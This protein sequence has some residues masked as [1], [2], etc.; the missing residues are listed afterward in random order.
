MVQQQ[1]QQP[2][3]TTE[4]K[5]RVLTAAARQGKL[6]ILEWMLTNWPSLLYTLSRETVAR[7]HGNVQLLFLMH[8]FKMQL[9]SLGASLTDSAHDSI[10]W[11]RHDQHHRVECLVRYLNVNVCNIVMS[12]TRSTVEAM[13]HTM[14]RNP[15]WL[16]PIP[17][18]FHVDQPRHS[19]GPCDWYPWLRGCRALKCLC[20]VLRCP[21]GVSHHNPHPPPI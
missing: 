18:V 20:S 5:S 21:C 13:S 1:Q 2:Q 19:G 8:D 3:D 4:T 7:C 12:Y 9:V 17:S 16:G 10:S 14:A 6:L 15:P 11:L